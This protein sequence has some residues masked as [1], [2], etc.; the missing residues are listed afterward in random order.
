[1]ITN[2]PYESPIL[3]ILIVILNM[4]PNWYVELQKMS[5]TQYELVDNT[6]EILNRLSLTTYFCEL[7][8]VVYYIIALISI[9]FFVD[10]MVLLSHCHDDFQTK[11][12]VFDHL[13]KLCHLKINFSKTNHTKSSK[14]AL[15][16]SIQQC[17]KKLLLQ[18]EAKYLIT[19]PKN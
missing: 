1:M 4:I 2:H 18:E 10:D 6:I 15:K 16:R 8:G 11:V 5:S 14:E 3:R 13:C 12:N 7:I 9:L 19:I 17:M